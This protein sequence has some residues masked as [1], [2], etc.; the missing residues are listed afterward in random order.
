MNTSISAG[1]PN[2]RDAEIVTTT[3]EAGS[4]EHPLNNVRDA[5]I[6]ELSLINDERQPLIGKTI[7]KI[8]ST[9]FMDIEPVVD[10]VITNLKSPCGNKRFRL[11]NR[12]VHLTYHYH[13]DPVKYL[14]C[15]NE[16]IKP[17]KVTVYCIAREFG[18]NKGSDS[19]HPHTH[20]ALEFSKTLRVTCSRFF[21]YLDYLRTDANPHPFIKKVSY[22][23]HWK[24]ICSTYLSKETVPFTNYTDSSGFVSYEE[25][26]ECKTKSDVLKAMRD[27]GVPMKEAGPYVTAFELIEKEKRDVEK[28]WK[29]WR[30]WQQFLINILDGNFHDPGERVVTWIYNEGGSIGKTQFSDYLADKYSGVKLTSQGVKNSLHSLKKEYDKKG[31]EI[32]I[33][34]I[35]IAKADYIDRVYSLIEKLK[36]K[37]ITSEKYDS[38]VMTFDKIPLVL[39]YSNIPPDIDRLSADRWMVHVP[40]FDGIDFEYT[41]EGNSAKKFNDMYINE[42]LKTQKL[43]EK[44]G[45]SYMPC[46]PFGQRNKIGIFNESLE[47]MPLVKRQT[48]WDRG[49]VPVL[50]MRSTPVGSTATLTEEP[51]DPELFERYKLWKDGSDGTAIS[52]IPTEEEIAANA[53]RERESLIRKARKFGYTDDELKKEFPD[54]TSE[55]LAYKPSRFD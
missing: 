40:M 50:T 21:D 35:D 55:E 29:K 2:N 43:A 46:V 34:I 48:Y 4:P 25:L 10:E 18:K 17:N 22:V 31:G 39:V 19:A 47:F 7:Q 42:E 15:I 9:G 27:N 13:F 24:H 30:P 49:M 54:I 53:I 20:V 8:I 28:P 26:Q 38:S 41:F 12:R 5:K 6:S 44:K 3:R 37:R 16:Y 52:A 33:V 45:E 32:P 1:P 11:E 14:D 23:K 51:M 36:S